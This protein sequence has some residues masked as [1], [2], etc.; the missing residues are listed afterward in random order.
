MNRLDC[1]MSRSVSAH[2]H[3]IEGLWEAGGGGPKKRKHQEAEPELF[4]SAPPRASL[5]DLGVSYLCRFPVATLS[6]PVYDRM[7][8]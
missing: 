1:K 5:Q 3:A 6:T 4:S 2:T 8:H 7:A